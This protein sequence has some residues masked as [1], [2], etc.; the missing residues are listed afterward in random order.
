ML[1][2]LRQP[3]SWSRPG[4]HGQRLRQARLRGR[5]WACAVLSATL[6]LL[7]WEVLDGRS[8]CCRRGV[9]PTAACRA[10]GP[11]TWPGA[12]TQ[13]DW[14]CVC[15]R[16][17]RDA[18]CSCRSRSRLEVAWD[19]ALRLAVGRTG[20]GRRRVTGSPRPPPQGW[21]LT[22]SR[23]QHRRSGCVLGG[24]D[25]RRPQGGADAHWLL[26]PQTP[27]ACSV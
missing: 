16:R 4:T 17:A 10:S 2:L 15:S 1:S 20:H 14:A 5:D 24:G 21:Q 9:G 13:A 19:S 18:A 11:K 23:Q 8:G 7:A 26:Q 12:A 22:A 25:A 6:G 3:L 27:K